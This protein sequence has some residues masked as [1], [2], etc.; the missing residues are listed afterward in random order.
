[1]YIDIDLAERRNLFRKVKVYLNGRQVQEVIAAKNGVNGF[2]K[3]A[4]IPL[5]VKN[6]EIV[7]LNKRGNV[8]ISFNLTG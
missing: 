3:H 1:M 5:Q 7:Y 4:K 8:K 2:V 6:N